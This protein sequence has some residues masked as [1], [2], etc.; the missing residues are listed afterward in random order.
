MSNSESVTVCVQE[1][2]ASAVLI[3]KYQELPDDA[4]KCRACSYSEYP[5]VT[6]TPHIREE[7]CRALMES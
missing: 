3:Q 7:N 4:G 5:A 6:W 1:I 2:P